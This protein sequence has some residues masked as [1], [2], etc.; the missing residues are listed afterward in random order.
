MVWTLI[1]NGSTGLIMVI[2]YAF[3]IGNVQEVLQSSTG[4]PFIEVF[5]T[6]TN[7][8]GATTGMTAIIMLLQF[9]ATISNVATTSRQLYAF[10]RDDGL[11]F[12]SFMSHVS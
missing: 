1:L 11:P 12:S 2:T 4:F 5:L 7:S 3:C 9:C 8:V 10:A 6:S